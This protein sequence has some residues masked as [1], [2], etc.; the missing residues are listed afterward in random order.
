MN[1]IKKVSSIIHTTQRFAS[2]SSNLIESNSSEPI[3][4]L[5]AS[6]SKAKSIAFDGMIDKVAERRAQKVTSK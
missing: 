5:S 4:S 3:L 1:S 6:K 2:T